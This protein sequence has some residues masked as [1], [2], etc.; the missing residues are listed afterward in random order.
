MSDRRQLHLAEDHEPF[1]ADVAH[2]DRVLFGA[3][4]TPLEALARAYH[5]IIVARFERKETK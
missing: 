5:R 2:A 1:I 4:G 3:V